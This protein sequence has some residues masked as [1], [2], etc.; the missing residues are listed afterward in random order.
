VTNATQE[1]FWLLESLGLSRVTVLT[2]GERPVPVPIVA[3]AQSLFARRARHEPLQ[4]ILGTQE[5]CGHAFAVGPG[6]LIPRPETEL[7]VQEAIRLLQGRLT[8]IA[9]D[10]GTGSGCVA[11]SVAKALPHSRVW[12]ADISQTALNVART[13]IDRHAVADRVTACHGDLLAPLDE[14]LAE[15]I[16]VILSNPPYIAESEWPALPR[17]VAEYEPRVALDGGPDGLREHR[18]LAD[19]A[20][21]W[22]APGGWLILE[23]GQGQR[24]PI[25]RY[26]NSTGMY[27]D[28]VVRKDHQG[29]ERLVAAQSSLR[30]G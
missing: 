21:Q 22:L 15:R 3:R 27:R 7:L 6:A 29:I 10:V 2:E 13:N 28:I 16:D 18:R 5:F 26:L 8:V 19:Q 1:T 4:Y 12:A 11:V 25:E 30:E 17:D 14:A 20:P 9:V 24:R 23:I